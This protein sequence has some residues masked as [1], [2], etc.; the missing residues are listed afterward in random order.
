MKDLGM[1]IPSAHIGVGFGIFTMPVNRIIQGVLDAHEKYGI[2][3][4][5]MT[6]PFGTAVSAL[7]WAK[8]VKTVSEAVKPHGCRIL[9]HNHDDELH[10]LRKGGPALDLFLRKTVPGLM[11]EIDIGWAGVTGDELEIVKRYADRLHTLH[12]KDIYA[13]YRIGYTHTNMPDCGFAPIGE[14][15]IRTGEIID[16][17]RKLP[18][19]SGNYI[20]DQDR[21]GG[22]ML[23]DLKV[24]YENIRRM[25]EE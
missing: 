23:E 16:L 2:E 3:T 10:S 18:N 6:A 19:F 15:A 4:F 24:G 21:S 7:R 8:L 12:L 20:I 25:L 9:Y 17:A 1:S 22:S 14:G 11:L 13:P 5:V